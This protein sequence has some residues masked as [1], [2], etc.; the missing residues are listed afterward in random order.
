MGPAKVAAARSTDSLSL[1]PRERSPQDVG[2]EGKGE[3]WAEGRFDPG[4]MVATEKVVRVTTD[5]ASK[6]TEAALFAAMLRAAGMD[7]V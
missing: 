4:R 6:E 1:S 2:G 5:D 7:V 3:G